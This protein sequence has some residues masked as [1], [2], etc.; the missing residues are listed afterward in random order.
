MRGINNACS[1]LDSYISIYGCDNVI[2][3]SFSQRVELVTFIEL[4]LE[5]EDSIYVLLSM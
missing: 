3:C 4:S 1:P 5:F 2:Y